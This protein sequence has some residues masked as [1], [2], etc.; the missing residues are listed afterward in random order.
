[1]FSLETPLNYTNMYDV[2]KSKVTAVLSGMA[3]LE[4]KTLQTEVS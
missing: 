1:M 3:E 4:I 2:S